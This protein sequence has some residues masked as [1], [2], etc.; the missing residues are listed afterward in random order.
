MFLFQ[1]ISDSVLEEYDQFDDYL[2]MVMQ[3]GVR[4]TIFG[5]SFIMTRCLR[6]I[7]DRRPLRAL[8]EPSI[9]L[10]PVALSKIVTLVSISVYYLICVRL[11]FGLCCWCHI[12][13]HRNPLRYV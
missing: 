5:F 6:A 9:R 3:F 8:S 13:V 7:N 12:S 2:E 4:F 10:E 11:S 1:A